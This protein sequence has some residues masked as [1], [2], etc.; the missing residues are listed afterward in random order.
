MKILVV[1]D[2]PK[3]AA[4]LVKGLKAESYLVD[5]AYDGNAAIELALVNDYDIILLDYLLP[6]R[7]GLEVLKEIRNQSC[8]SKVL[9]LT[10]KDAIQDKVDG[11]NMGADD[12]MVKPFAFEELLARIRVLLRRGGNEKLSLLLADDLTLNL[13]NH[14]VSRAGEKIELSVKEYALLEYF[15]RHQNE[16]VSRTQLWEHVWEM[17]INSFSNVVDVYVCYL[18]NKIDKKPFKPLIQTLR[19]QGYILKTDD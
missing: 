5:V 4:A 12:Y 8:I 1:E 17:D 19:G 9:M 13:L 14:E 18:R 2:E 16:L 7:S 10:A 15:L 3:L 6:K 11:L